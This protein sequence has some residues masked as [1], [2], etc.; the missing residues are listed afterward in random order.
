VR[1]QV[2]DAVARIDGLLAGAR[3]A[4][5]PAD[6]LLLTS[7]HGNV[8]SLA[9][10]AHTR[11]PVPLLAFGPGASDF[12]AVTDISQVADA[13]VSSIERSAR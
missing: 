5:R 11:N 4:M 1:D 12:A 2:H 3:A 10:P 13:I 8:E 7:D 6:T 9:A